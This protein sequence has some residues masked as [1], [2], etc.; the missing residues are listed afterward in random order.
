MCFFLRNMPRPMGKYGKKR[1]VKPSNGFS[2]S[3]YCGIDFDT[4]K[5]TMVCVS[6]ER[7]PNHSV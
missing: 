2:R 5:K 3:P 7:P 6:P 1:V 4:N